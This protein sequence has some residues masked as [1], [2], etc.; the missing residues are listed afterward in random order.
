MSHNIQHRMYPENV[1]R[2]DV[3]KEI[4]H[5]VSMEDWQEGCSG[6]YHS[7]RWIET[8]ICPDYMSAMK[9]LESLDRGDYDNLAIRFYDCLPFEDAKL[10]ELEEKKAVAWEKYLQV[11]HIIYPKTIKAA[12]ITCK[13]C[14][15]KLS[16]ARLTGNDCPLCKT[17]LR[18]DHLKDRIKAA[19]DRF[20]KAGENVRQYRM[21][22]A[23]KEVRWLVKFE[24]HT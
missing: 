13:V 10:K 14:G 8:E 2:Q 21:K 6:L 18:P 22:K 19:R 17:S 12:Y 23:K 4:D 1:N 7:I 11:S 24:Y 3:K 20:E 15:S 16:R 9:K 5:Y